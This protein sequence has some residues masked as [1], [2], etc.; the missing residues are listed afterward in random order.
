MI[1]H[2]IGLPKSNNSPPHEDD[3]LINR[4]SVRSL[5][6]ARGSSFREI[7]G[8]MAALP[9]LFTTPSQGLAATK[10]NI[11]VILADDL[12]NSDLGAFGSEIRT[13]NLDSLAKKGKILK[14]FYS[15]PTCSPTRSELISGTD[16]HL[17]GL[18]SMAELLAPEQ[19]GKPGYEGFLRK[20][21]APL[22]SLLRDAGYNTYMSG[23][24]HLGGAP[25]YRPGARG[26]DKSFAL[27]PGGASHFKQAIQ[28]LGGN[29]APEPTY[30]E[31]DKVVSTPEDFY[32][33]KTYTDKIL[34]YIDSGRG[35][36]KPFFAYLAYTAPHWPVQ[37][38]DENLLKVRGR[39]DVGY[40]IISSQRFKRQ[41]QLGLIPANAKQ[42][43]LPAGIQPWSQLSP[44]EKAISARTYEAY[45]AAVESLDEHIGRLIQHLRNTGDLDNTFILFLSDNG[46]EGND[47]SKFGI[48]TQPTTGTQ[49]QK[50][51]YAWLDKEF[52]NSLENI[53][54]KNSYA[55]VKEGW[56]QASA[57]PYRNYKGT[58][59]EGGIHVPA[60]AYYP[61]SIKPGKVS[62]V[63]TVRDILP[64][65]LELAGTSHPGTTYQGNPVQPIQGV[66]FLSALQEPG[67]LAHPKNTAFGFELFGHSALR[68]GDWKIDR[69]YPPQGDGKWHLYKVGNDQAE[70]TDKAA[71][72]SKRFNQLQQEWQSYV[73]NNNVIELG[74]NH[75]YGWIDDSLIRIK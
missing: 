57:L 23:K 8:F 66:S 10:P 24:W 60:I 14:N 1:I 48:S 45:A 54:R 42:P 30:T 63:A 56:G 26:F 29:A 40:D 67:K 46:A 11:I 41:K 32:S 62:A 74:Y 70:L 75:G 58:V 61:K 27:M 49:Y 50:D 55:W 19:R 3:N 39:Y 36:G 64:T 47:I 43:P 51:F 53:G 12:G 9:L 17:A 4:K 5:N 44:G 73:K 20:D 28:R 6:R 37:A 59:T 52:D 68:Q 72:Q 33:T 35:S 22:P 31:N 7:F 16:H 15:Q 13:P 34:E 18:G 21:I 38:P 25:D 69:I 2:S 71:G 65:A